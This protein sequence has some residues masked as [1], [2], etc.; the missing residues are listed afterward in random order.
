MQ[1]LRVATYNVHKCR[2]MDGRLSVARILAVLIEMRADI[3]GLQEVLSMTRGPRECDQARFLAD[4]LEMH[5]A[6]GENRKIEGGAY[7]NIVLSRYPVASYCNHNV[8]IQG[9]EPRGCLQTDVELPDGGTLHVFNAHFGTGFLERRRQAELLLEKSILQAGDAPRVVL[10]DFNEW[11]AGHLTR[12][13]N[14]QFHG[15][16][17]RHRLRWRRSYPGWLPLLHLDHIY[18]DKSLLLDN[19][20]LHR[21]QLSLMASDHVPIVADFRIAPLSSNGGVR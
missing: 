10:G 7:G 14:S 11:T 17:I 15:A 1:A 13:L 6:M 20:S 5:L 21:T 2:G 3:V 8:S 9:Y 18:Y 12:T 19:V 4:E 16:D